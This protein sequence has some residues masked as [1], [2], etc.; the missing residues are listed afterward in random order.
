MTTR[1]T[2]LAGIVLFAAIPFHPPAF[3][4]EGYIRVSGSYAGA[5][6]KAPL[7]SYL[8]SDVLNAL[9]FILTFDNPMLN[10]S[11]QEGLPLTESVH[12]SYGK[13]IAAEISGGYM[14]HRHVGLELGISYL[15]GRDVESYWNLVP[16]LNTKSTGKSRFSSFFLTPSLVISANY[17]ALN[18]YLRIGAVLGLTPKIESELYGYFLGLPVYEKDELNGGIAAGFSGAF[19]LSY[20]LSKKISFFGEV[21]YR[22]VDYKPKTR[23]M[24]EISI[25][26]QKQDISSIYLFPKQKL[27]DDAPLTINSNT[28]E[29]LRAYSS[30]V[31]SIALNF[32]LEC[33]FGSK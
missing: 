25:L 4:Q 5:T 33:R 10:I 15:F 32:G 26:G 8:Q 19:G 24:V 21:V 30:P 6:A 14:F 12:D 28:E 20:P 18:P 16:L 27:E 7:N 2:L 31:N 1:K 29:T 3:S 22:S 17:K 13:G 11:V 23:Q 9:G